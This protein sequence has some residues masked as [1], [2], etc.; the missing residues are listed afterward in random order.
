MLAQNVINIFFV[1][2]LATPAVAFGP[3]KYKE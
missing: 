1:S 3:L 2:L